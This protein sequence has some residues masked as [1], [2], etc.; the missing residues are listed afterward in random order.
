MTNRT[1][2]YLF[3][4]EANEKIHAFPEEYVISYSDSVSAYVAATSALL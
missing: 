2:Y 3:R 1:I 4:G